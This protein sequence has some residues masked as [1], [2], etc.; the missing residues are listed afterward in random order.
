[1]SEQNQEIEIEVD[2]SEDHESVVL[3]FKVES[4]TL[5]L[6]LDLG[7]AQ[8]LSTMLNDAVTGLLLQKMGLP[9]PIPETRH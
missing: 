5:V 1:M 7:E 8:L 4:R 9:P 3:T 2:A 6:G